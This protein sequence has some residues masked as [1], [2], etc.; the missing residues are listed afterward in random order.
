ML[1]KTTSDPKTSLV[2][3]HEQAE[4]NYP[5]G[6]CETDCMVREMTGSFEGLRKWQQTG[7]RYH[8]RLCV[9]FYLN[10]AWDPNRHWVKIKQLTLENHNN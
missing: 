3:S 8:D 7:I 1:C 10:V 4:L 6:R 5:N 2:L 9:H